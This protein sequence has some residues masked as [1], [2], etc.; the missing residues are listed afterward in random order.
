MAFDFI[1]EYKKHI[2]QKASLFKCFKKYLC[3]SLI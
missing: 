1:K 2:L 3:F